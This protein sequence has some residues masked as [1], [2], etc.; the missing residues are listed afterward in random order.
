MPPGGGLGHASIEMTQKY[1]AP[2]EGEAATR[3]N[4]V[5][6][7]DEECSEPV[8]LAQIQNDLFS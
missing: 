4:H 8:E 5:A 1:L 3:V 7:E 6:N 2:Q